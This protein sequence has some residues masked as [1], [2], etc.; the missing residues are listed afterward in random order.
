MD[1]FLEIIT[2][3]YDRLYDEAKCAN[4]RI[5]KEVNRIQN[6]IDKLKDLVEDGTYTKKEYLERKNKHETEIALKKINLNETNI[7]I[8]EFET[9]KNNTKR[10]FEHLPTFW[11]NLSHQQKRKM[12]NFLFK[13]GLI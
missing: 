8:P 11:I 4:S 3:E 12:T 1:L 13:D 6:K 5:Q 2:D 9:C 7:D 10:F